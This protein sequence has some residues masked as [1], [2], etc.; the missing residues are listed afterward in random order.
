MAAS[1]VSGTAHAHPILDRARNRY[2][3]ADFQGALD[4]LARAENARNLT[5]SDVISL[6]A[7]RVLVHLA[8]EDRDALGADLLRLASLAPDFRFSDEAPPEAQ[9]AFDTARRTSPGALELAVV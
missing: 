2:Y 1:V 6:L 8:M 5:R 4:Q 3:D 9:Q 7:L